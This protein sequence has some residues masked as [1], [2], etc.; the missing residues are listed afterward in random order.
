MGNCAHQR[1]WFRAWIADEKAEAR[2]EPLTLSSLHA[3]YVESF[4]LRRPYTQG[5]VQSEVV[6]GVEGNHDGDG[7][8][9]EKAFLF[10]C[11]LH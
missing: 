4:G 7:R 5:A 6:Q 3:S 8:L 1:Q 9:W 2:S 10:A 11:P